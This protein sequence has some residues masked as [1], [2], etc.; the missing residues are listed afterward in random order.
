M[1]ILLD[2]QASRLAVIRTE[3]G[4]TIALIL[5]EDWADHLRDRHR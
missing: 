1:P 2:V 5:E 4:L 3:R